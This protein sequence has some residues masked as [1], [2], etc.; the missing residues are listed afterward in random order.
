MSATADRRRPAY[1]TP[2]LVTAAGAAVVGS[3]AALNRPLARA[4]APASAPVTQAVATGAATRPATTQASDE[5]KDDTVAKVE[6]GTIDLRLDLD[7]TFEPVDPFEVRLKTKAYQ[8]EYTIVRAADPGARVKK[9]DVLLEIDAKQARRQLAAAE[10]ELTVA[11][12][13]LDKAKADVALGAAADELAI[14]AASDGVRYAEDGVKWW[15]DND[16]KAVVAMTNIND[17]I[18]AFQVD[19]A[20]DELDQLR[21]MYKSE[22][23]ASETAD[24]VI[25]RATAVL[26]IYRGMREANGYE[27]RKLRE[28]ILGRNREEL[29]RGVDAT[30]QSVDQLK[31]SQAQGVVARKAA[32]TT[33]QLAVDAAADKLDDLK[34]D[35]DLLTVRSDADGVVV[36]GAF[37]S[38]TWAALPPEQLK[39]G[40]KVQPQQVL[41][42]VFAPGKLRATAGVGESKLTLVKRGQKV[43]VTPALLSDVTYDGTLA[44]VKLTGAGGSPEQTFEATIDLP[45]VDE[46]IAPGFK[47]SAVIDNGKLEN[48]L[49]VPV[50]AVGKGR[51]WVKTGEGKDAKEEPRDVVV[52]RSDGMN[53]EIKSGL[54][55]GEQVLKQ[56]KK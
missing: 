28:Y 11:R 20:V 34:R 22:D 36:Y 44:S 52:G 46:R 23:L 24:I 9:G 39:S 2:L 21:K 55:E 50:T 27:L 31:A 40:E 3:L 45:P 32:E 7:A 51:V 8:G 5:K 25:K 54:T 12:A 15:D 13:N 53:V 26:D 38:G 48:V 56:A 14:K 18:T 29:T 19:S 16:A 42:T 43:R 17:K 30:K 35:A 6:R 4:D 41:M 10:N 33:A 37:K 1:R 49:T 47:A